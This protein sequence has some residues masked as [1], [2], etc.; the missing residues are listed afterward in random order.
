MAGAGM[1]EAEKSQSRTSLVCGVQA[2]MG[3][4][5]AIEL[6]DGTALCG[7]ISHVDCYM[8]V[9]MVEVTKVSK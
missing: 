7:K 8:N 6:R 3:K 1:N 2:L 5:T 9:E 4:A